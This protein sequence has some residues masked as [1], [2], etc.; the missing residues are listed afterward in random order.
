MN[1]I[2]AIQ[3]FLSKIKQ[4]S[5]CTYESIK[6]IIENM[7]APIDKKKLEEIKEKIIN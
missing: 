4:E 3:Y 1:K 7:D 6:E 5:D 2:E